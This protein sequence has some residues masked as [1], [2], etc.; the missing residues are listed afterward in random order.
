ME[1]KSLCNC[2]DAW[3]Y[4]YISQ[5]VQTNNCAQGKSILHQQ[6]WAQ[7][8]EATSFHSQPDME[9]NVM[10]IL[11]PFLARQGWITSIGKGHTQLP[12]GWIHLWGVNL[13][14]LYHKGALQ[15]IG[16]VVCMY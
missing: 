1:L 6:H 10:I 14:S 4:R 16:L 5:T 9:K 15:V 3:P 2:S 13:L 7:T 11:F 12:L 8:E